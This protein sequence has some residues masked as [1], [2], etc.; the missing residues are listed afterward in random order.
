MA[1]L[2]KGMSGNEVAL[3]QTSL[4]SFDSYM[5]GNIVVDGQYG[6]ATENYVK[7]F[8]QMKKLT[9]DGIAGPA[10]LSALGMT[11]SANVSDEA[12]VASNNVSLSLTTKIK[13]MFVQ[14]PMPV[15]YT[16]GVLAVVGVAVYIKNQ[17]EA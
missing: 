9:V 3:L 13:D 8:Q 1:T 12:L 17:Q 7:I 16:V 15:W 6:S 2:R 11:A 14:V 10:T 4:K 5:F